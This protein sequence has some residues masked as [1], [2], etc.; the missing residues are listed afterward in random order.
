MNRREVLV[1][2]AALAVTAGSSITAFGQ[3]A[4]LRIG[5]TIWPGWM[6][7][8]IVTEKDM[9]KTVGANAEI[10][11]FK[12]HPDGMAAFAGKQLD[13]HHMILADVIIP[14]SKGVPGQVVLVTDE[15]SGADG[16]LAKPEITSIADFKG[17]RIAYEF[18]GVSQLILT[19]ALE[20]AG[21][22]IDDIN[23]VNMSSE[24]SGTA[25]MAGALDV[26]VTWEPYLG[27]AVKDG[28]GKVIFST[29]DT[30]GLV[31]DL[32]V[33]RKEAVESRA[34]D[35]QKVLS[36][37]QMA[38]DFLATNETEAYEIMASGAGITPDEM[39]ANM[40][41][42][43]LYSIAENVAAFD[44]S[45]KGNLIETIEE[46]SAF[47]KGHE[48]IDELPVAKDLVAP[49]FVITANKG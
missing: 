18:G 32:L 39:R 12:R 26:A 11:F 19:R 30:P 15:S 29:K 28:K 1:G 49:Q 27:Q 48:I 5:L 44:P 31:P 47:L 8:W 43:K 46:Q 33:F 42:V 45:S 36:A 38:L 16:I 40:A 14:A 34:D 2:T 9:L 6:P 7:W 35:I 20:T 25:F 24:D 37:W 3:P 13:A 10:V 23:S 41:G 21:L 17:K 22:T 4:P